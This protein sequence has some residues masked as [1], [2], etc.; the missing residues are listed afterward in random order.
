MSLL[1]SIQ[2]DFASISE[3]AGLFLKELPGND[4]KKD[5]ILAAELAG[6]LLQRG[7]D[8]DLSKLEPGNVV[9]GAID[10]ETYELMHR[11]LFAAAQS[12]GLDPTGLFKPELPED[13]DVYYPEITEYETRLYSICKD[14]DVKP[15]YYP[16]I[17]A[18]TAIRLIMAGAELEIMEPGAG[19]AMTLYHINAGSKTVPYDSS[20]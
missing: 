18:F 9:L 17:S 19:L 4:I 5:V 10:D 2:K 6:L 7:S 15:E 13:I 14:Q 20:K 11:F 8:V 12:G 1:E 3:T 16:F